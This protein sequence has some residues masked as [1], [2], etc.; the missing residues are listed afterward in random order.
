[1]GNV[2]R[3]APLAETGP[4]TGVSF[5]HRSCFAQRG[6]SFKIRIKALDLGIFSI[7]RPDEVQ[8]PVAIFENF[9]K[10]KKG[11]MRTWEKKK[12]DEEDKW[13]K[14]LTGGEFDVKSENVAERYTGP[15]EA[16]RARQE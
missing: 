12:K 14:K 9:C 13:E 1:V 11:E 6:S 4:R 5:K 3:R 15:T 7:E 16:I 10:S 2:L 8:V